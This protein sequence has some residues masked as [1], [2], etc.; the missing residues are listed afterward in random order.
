MATMLEYQDCVVSEKQLH[1]VKAKLGVYG[2]NGTLDDRW[3]H[4]A[5][6]PAESKAVNDAL[7]ERIQY[8][9]SVFGEGPRPF[10]PWGP[11]PRRD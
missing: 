5:A 7:R 1:H 11:M 8:L 10:E 3:F 6:Y 4:A 9:R 2:G